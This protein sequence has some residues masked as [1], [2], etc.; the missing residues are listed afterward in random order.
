M[1]GRGPR[2]WGPVR[3]HGVFERNLKDSFCPVEGLLSK[4]G[5]ERDGGSIIGQVSSLPRQEF[6]ELLGAAHAHSRFVFVLIFSI[7]FFFFFFLLFVCLLILFVIRSLP[8]LPFFSGRRPITA[9]N[10][11]S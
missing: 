2:C 7:F 8:S 5:D 4:R 1:D 6:R 11:N 3:I 9:G 10:F